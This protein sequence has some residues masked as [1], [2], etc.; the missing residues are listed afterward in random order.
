[1]SR[2]WYILKT[3]LTKADIKWLNHLSNSK[4]VKI[5][6]YNPKVKSMFEKQRKEILGI[7]GQNIK[8]LHFGASGLGISGQ[9]EIDVVIPTSLNNF[10]KF[11]EKLKRIYGEPR[12]FSPGNRVRF[13]H[14]QSDINIEIVIVNKNSEGWKRNLEFDLYLRTHPEALEAYRKLKES[15]H[16]MGIRKYYRKKMEF[17][18]DILACMISSIT[19]SQ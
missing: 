16:G 15:Y 3:M 1:M 14:K 4:K 2:L 18:N 19:P 6:P 9:K 8:V 5:V 12:S 13:N 17:I 7:L 11:I 10:D